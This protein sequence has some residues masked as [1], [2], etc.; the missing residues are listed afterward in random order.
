M[1]VE[2][3]KAVY[4]ARQQMIEQSNALAKKLIEQ[5]DHK[6]ATKVMSEMIDLLKESPMQEAL[7]NVPK[8]HALPK[9][10]PKPILPAGMSKGKVAAI[11]AGVAI[12]GGGIMMYHNA[13]KKKQESWTARIE[14]QRNSGPQ[15]GAS[16]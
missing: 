8:P 7:K 5:G 11:V 13:Q 6:G 15:R 3:L 1:S 2:T 9:T 14:Q 4:A 16:L 10:P 12:V